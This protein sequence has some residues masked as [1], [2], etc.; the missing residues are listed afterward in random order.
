MRQRVLWSCEGLSQALTQ[1]Q[2][3][4][5]PQVLPNFLAADGAQSQARWRVV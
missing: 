2:K 4:E 5:S 3:Q 1:R